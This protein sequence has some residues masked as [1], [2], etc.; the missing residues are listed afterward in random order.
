MQLKLVRPLLESDDFVAYLDAI[1]SLRRVGTNVTVPSPGGWWE[2]AGM[3]L[4]D[5]P[6]SRRLPEV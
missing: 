1:E 6:S 4:Q 2:Q 5:I 3:T